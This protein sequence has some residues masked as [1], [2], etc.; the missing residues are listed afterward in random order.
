MRVASHADLGLTRNQKLGQ[1]RVA[2]MELNVV[3]RNFLQQIDRLFIAVVLVFGEPQQQLE[4]TR[5]G[6]EPLFPS[7]IS[8]IFKLS[9][10]LPLLEQI[11][12]PA[13]NIKLGVRRYPIRALE[14]IRVS[15][16]L[17]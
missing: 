14:V 10:I 5:L 6:D 16:R 12:V 9:R 4:I 2:F 15:R 11:R 8:K 7:G 3:E 17:G 13:G 1:L